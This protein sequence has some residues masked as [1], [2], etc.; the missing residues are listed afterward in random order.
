MA[1]LLTAGSPTPPGM[2]SADARGLAA[3]ERGMRIIMMDAG[4]LLLV[5]SFPGGGADEEDPSG[6]WELVADFADVMISLSIR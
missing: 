2:A 3:A 6:P 1:G 4:L 5:A